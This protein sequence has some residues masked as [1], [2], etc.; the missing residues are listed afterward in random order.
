MANLG[1]PLK[2]PKLVDYHLKGKTEYQRER[3]TRQFFVTSF[4]KNMAPSQVF[5]EVSDDNLLKFPKE[6]KNICLYFHP[7]LVLYNL[8]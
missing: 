5:V 6:N 2:S 1:V 4:C 7:V 8:L 3:T